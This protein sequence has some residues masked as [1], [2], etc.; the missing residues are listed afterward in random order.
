MQLF[1][2]D[3]TKSLSNQN[4]HGLSF[5]EIQVLWQDTDLIE[6]PAMSEGELRYLVV[7]KIADKHWSAVITYRAGDIRIISARR[8]RETEVVIYE[9]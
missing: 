9:S 6:I 7:G 3:G 1:E 5:E 4:K 8:S 2:F